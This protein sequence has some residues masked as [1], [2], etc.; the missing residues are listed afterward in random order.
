[1]NTYS[2]LQD[3]IRRAV[4]RSDMDVEIPNWIMMF[5]REMALILRRREMS[6]RATADTV[7]SQQAYAK[8]EDFGDGI[9]L[10][11]TADGVKRKLVPSDWT[12]VTTRYDYEGQPIEWAITADEFVLGPTPDDVYPL[13][14]YYYKT[15]PA[16]ADEG[17]NWLLTSYPRLYLFGS[18]VQS[19]GMLED[20]QQQAWA[21]SYKDA[22][23]SLVKD[24]VKER[25]FGGGP[26]LRVSV[27]FGSTC[28]GHILTD[29]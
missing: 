7:A 12:R 15:I 1:M 2:T 14:L 21:M 13:E 24:Q 28:S 17:T 10:Y 9:D 16:L 6:S 19:V 22:L 8:P 26:V 4:K 29:E 3:S 20:P 25:G 18:L 5:E 27:P 11:M 23:A